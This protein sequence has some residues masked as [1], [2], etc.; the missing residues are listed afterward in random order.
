MSIGSNTRWLGMAIVLVLLV[1]LFPVGAAFADSGSGTEFVGAIQS[2]P[3]ASLIGDWQVGGKTV[4]VTNLTY[5]EQKHGAAVVGA[6]VEIKGTPQSNGSINALAIEVKPAGGGNSKSQEVKFVGVVKTLPGSGLIG[7]WTVAGIMTGTQSV[8]VTVHVSA[9]TKIS[10]EHG[11]VE[12]GSLVKV[13]GIKQTDNSV[14]A[15]EIEVMHGKPNP[16]SRIEFFGKIETLPGSGLV[17]DW[18]VN[19]RTVHVSSKTEIDQKNGKAVVGAFVKVEGVVQPDGSINASEIEVRSNNPTPDPG[20]KYIKFY[21]IIQS[22]PASGS[23][24]DW[25]INGLTVH[26]TASTIIDKSDG[27]PAVGSRAEVKGILQTDGSINAIK[28]ES[29]KAITTSSPF[30][31]AA[32]VSSN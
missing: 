32:A 26:V 17:G 16:G 30:G 5:I 28:I 24:G 29:K 1:G 13:E 2:L 4:H 12:V 11:K 27:V 18:T 3:G 25:T 20:N 6:M 10:Q 19:S 23:I 15:T 14:K 8:T 31:K 9:T 21:G 22:L 7:D